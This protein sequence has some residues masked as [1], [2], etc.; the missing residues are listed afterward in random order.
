MFE[1]WVRYQNKP[2]YVKFD[3]RKSR[4]FAEATMKY[5]MGKPE[6]FRTYIREVI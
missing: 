1:V 5:L 3:T 6:V 4:K 2:C